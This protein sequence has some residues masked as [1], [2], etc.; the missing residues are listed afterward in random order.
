MHRYGVLAYYI[1]KPKITN[2]K[3]A[4]VI[5]GQLEEDQIFNKKK[6]KFEETIYV[7]DYVLEGKTKAN[8]SKH[9]EE[10]GPL[11]NKKLL[12]IRKLQSS[13]SPPPTPPNHP[14][15]PKNKKLRPSPSV[16]AREYPNQIKLGND[17]RRYKSTMNKN[18]VY[19]WKILK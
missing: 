15:S 10:I 16:K 6:G 5:Y 11:I 9:I 18:G 2:T 17:G 8:I 19:T 13:S 4:N 14:S 7:Y 1:R 3:Y 12:I